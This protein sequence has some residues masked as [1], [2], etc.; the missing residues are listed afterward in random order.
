[1]ARFCNWQ[2]G[3][4]FSFGMLILVM[5]ALVVL[6][7]DLNNSVAM[8]SAIELLVGAPL[9]LVGLSFIAYL[10]ALRKRGP[11]Y[12]VVMYGLLVLMLPLSPVCVGDFRADGPAVPVPGP[13]PVAIT[14]IAGIK[15]GKDLHEP[16]SPRLSHPPGAAMPGGRR[17]DWPTLPSP[18]GWGWPSV[19]LLAL[20]F[21]F[22]GLGRFSAYRRAVETALDDIFRQNDTAAGNVINSID[23]PALLFDS[24]GKIVW[25]NHAFRELYK[26]TDLCSLIPGLDPRYPNKAQSLDYNG[27]SFQLMNMTVQRSGRG[28]RHL[29]FQYW[30][31][32]TEALHYSRL[33]E[34]Q[35]PTVAIIQIDNYDDLNADKQ[36]HRNTVL[37]E[38]ERKISRFCQLH[39]RGVSKLRRIQIFRG[40]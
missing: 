19:C 32:R 38:V 39:R 20:V 5:G 9:A 24:E 36:F 3:R 1:M 33:Y 15:K 8:A 4:S 35:M 28:I 12:L 13:Q 30:V 27:R 14:P 10:R 21:L 37:T 7:L 6:M 22:V 17:A 29:T 18:P 2:L 40:V 26:G 16:F 25:A 34:E 23:I 11:G 31:D